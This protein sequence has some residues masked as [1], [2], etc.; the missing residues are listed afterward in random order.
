MAMKREVTLT[1][2][3]IEITEVELGTITKYERED[4]YCENALYHILEEQTRAVQVDYDGHFGNYIY[5]SLEPKD[6]NEEQWEQIEQI[7][8]EFIVNA[9]QFLIAGEFVPEDY[10][11]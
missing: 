1:K 6:D 11:D 7:I 9:K 10:F 8:K 5:V 3:A 4:G 2:Y